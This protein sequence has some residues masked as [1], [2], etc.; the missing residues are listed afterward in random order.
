MDIK[1]RIEGLKE[2]I[3]VKHTEWLLGHRAWLMHVH[4]IF[5]CQDLIMKISFVH[6][7]FS[8]SS[9]NMHLK[10][11]PVTLNTM[12]IHVMKDTLRVVRDLVAGDLP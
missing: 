12:M 7:I 1:D 8:S 4:Y 6:V 9:G 10:I 5:M 3:F 11:S 2:R